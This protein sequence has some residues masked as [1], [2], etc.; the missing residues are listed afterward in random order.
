LKIRAPHRPRTPAFLDTPPGSARGTGWGAALL[1]LG[2]CLLA[3]TGLAA[4]AGDAPDGAALIASV[5]GGPVAGVLMLALFSQSRTAVPL[6]RV[7]PRLRRHAALLCWATLLVAVDLALPG[8]S[9]TAAIIA[10]ALAAVST[11]SL[12]AAQA[13]RLPAERSVKALMAVGTGEGY[14]VE[15][16]SRRKPAWLDLSGVVVLTGAGVPP[17]RRLL[18]AIEQDEPQ[19]LL[20]DGSLERLGI[21]GIAA[22]QEHG[23][24][25]WSL[26]SSLHRPARVC[27][28][29]ALAGLLWQPLPE[30]GLSPWQLRGKRAFDFVAVLVALPFALP[31]GALIAA[32]V[33]LTSRGPAIYS[34]VRVRARGHLFVIRKFRTMVESAEVDRRATMARGRRD[35]RLTSLGRR[36]RD[37]RLDEL[38]QLWN[39]LRGHMSLVGPRPERPV[40]VDE[41][42][43]RIPE[44]HH[45]HLVPVGLTGLAQLTGDYA[46]TPEEKL[47]ADLLYAGN[48]S[49]L[50]DLAL[51]ART[52][53]AL[54]GGSLDPNWIDVEDVPEELAPINPVPISHE[55]A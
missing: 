36:L 18:D 46:S 26:A 50:L 53:V 12:W 42:A 40:F 54:F 4:A 10:F 23:V 43:E 14:V 41:F 9:A 37:R 38:P 39:V 22:V 7:A 20:V 15:S 27:R 32:A 55:A 30:I 35:P 51:I 16:V 25:V 13:S 52:A 1:L 6:P 49:I 3:G 21:T 31:A 19:L 17:T 33:K 2:A 48:W 29:R 45:R 8:S 47:Q 11:E 44:Y 34:Q 5:V 28:L 24:A